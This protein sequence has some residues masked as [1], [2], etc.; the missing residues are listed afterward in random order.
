MTF[1]EL[2]SIIANISIWSIAKIFV[3]LALFLYIIFAW[4]VIRQVDLMLK[5]LTL[6]TANSTI[7]LPIK[8]VAYLQLVLAVVVFLTALVIL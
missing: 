6:K 3:L 2:L 1:E 4:L 5:T 7:E 8:L